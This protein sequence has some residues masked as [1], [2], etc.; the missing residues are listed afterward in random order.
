[1]KFLKLGV[2]FVFIIFATFLA[3]ANDND[4]S[5][6]T[7]SLDDSLSIFNEEVCVDTF[8]NRTCI[9]N[10]YVQCNGITQK[11]LGLTTFTIYET[12]YET[13]YVEI[14]SEEKL[15]NKEKPSPSDRIK[16]S[17]IEVMSNKIIINIKNANWRDFIDSNS[18]DPLIDEGSTTI[19]I[20]PKSE[21]EIKVGDIISYN[22][23]GYEFV[24]VHR[25][26][27][28]GN[29][30]QGIYFTTKGDNYF[31]EDPYKVRFSDLEGIVVGI[32]Y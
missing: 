23:D 32:W 2:V 27:E 31:Q 17:D 8:E 16:N 21:D 5:D 22:L 26:V 20:Q 7:A 18:M 30:E 13:E 3:L 29:D 25:V 6:I 24:V 14:S 28:I 4:I 1:M 19:E 9:E 12:I 11:I 15:N 10:T